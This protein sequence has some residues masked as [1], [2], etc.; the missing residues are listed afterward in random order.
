V[1]NKKLFASLPAPTPMPP[2]DTRNTA[3]GIAY[4]M[5]D[6]W[7]LAQ[8]AFTGTFGST[9]YD[10]SGGENQL[11][12]LID[13]ASRVSDDYIGRLA[14]A[15]RSVGFMK[16]MPAA[17]VC[18]SAR[19]MQLFRRVFDK[20][21]DAPNVLKEVFQMFRSGRFGHRGLGYAIKRAFER[22]LRNASPSWLYNMSIG[23]D[24]SLRDVFRLLH[25]KPNTLRERAMWGWLTGQAEKRWG[26]G[27]SSSDL[28]EL[29]KSLDAY[30]RVTSEGEQLEL[31]HHLKDVRF[32]AKSSNARGPRVWKALVADMKPQALR[33]NLNAMLKHGAFSDP[34]IVEMVYLK[35]SDVEAVRGSR[36][37]PF[38][39][40]AA[41]MYA[42]Q[43][44][45]QRIRDG[46]HKAAD[47]TCGNVPEFG[48][49][50]ALLVD[51]SGSMV[52]QSVTG[53]QGP[54]R[55]S[56]VKCVDAAALFAVALWRKN[57]GSVLVPFDT[58]VHTDAFSLDPG[59]TLLSLTSR[60]ARYGGGGTDCGMSLRFVNEHLRD[61]PF[62]AAIMISDNQS[63]ADDQQHGP[64]GVRVEFGN[65]VANQQRLGKYRNPKLMCVDLCPDNT[66]QTPDVADTLNVGGFSDGVFNLIS[67][68]ISGD[69]MRFVEMIKKTEL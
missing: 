31:V 40:L 24:P 33:M 27:A 6:E 26:G 63:W 35:L 13:H 28:P 65:F 12:M 56:K 58:R 42:D 7:A 16:S 4:Q 10:L 37:F 36:Q 15:S 59:D 18:L 55:E 64:T 9:F 23:R 19:D 34:E 62:G 61:R 51:V 48:C 41:Y 2:A 11:A 54:G 32:E 5:D 45:P 60:L 47:M 66:C 69:R 8:L 14:V 3:G 1:A 20:V 68:F 46:L 57:P 39:Y 21:V 50:V 17:L 25:M 43:A 52:G 67:Q 44:M 29:F 30:N 53:S 49:P 38:Q 22:K